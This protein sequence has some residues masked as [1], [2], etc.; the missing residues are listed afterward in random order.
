MPIKLFIVFFT[1]STDSIPTK[2]R[3]LTSRKA[4]PTQLKQL[5]VSGFPLSTHLRADISPRTA[6]S[7]FATYYAQLDISRLFSIRQAQLLGGTASFAAS[8]FW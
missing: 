4:M 2:E 1:F 3:N 8:P 7:A 5:G 6:P